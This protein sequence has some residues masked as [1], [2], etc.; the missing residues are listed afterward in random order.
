MFYGFVISGIFLIIWPSLPT[1]T[2]IVKGLTYG[3]GMWFFRVLMGVISNWMMFHV[4]VKTL[5]YFLFAGLIEMI[6]LGII[7]GLILKR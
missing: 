5:L 3:L 6:I 4:P 2:G 7:N 1:E